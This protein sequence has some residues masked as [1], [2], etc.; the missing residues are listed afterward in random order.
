MSEPLKI[1]IRQM[2]SG[3]KPTPRHYRLTPSLQLN[4]MQ[5]PA[6]L[7]GELP[8]QRVH[9]NTSF[10]TRQGLLNGQGCLGLEDW[11]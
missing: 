2:S 7:S 9:A 5:K 3:L 4:I 1:T 11:K 6:R 10:S 8:R